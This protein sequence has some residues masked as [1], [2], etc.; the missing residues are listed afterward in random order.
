MSPLSSRLLS[1]RTSNSIYSNAHWRE[2]TRLYI[3]W[4][5]LSSPCHRDPSKSVASLYFPPS[6]PRRLRTPDSPLFCF[7]ADDDYVIDATSVSLAPT[8]S[9]VTSEFT[10][11]IE[12]RRKQV[13]NNRPLLSWPARMLPPTR[14]TLR[15]RY[16]RRE[17]LEGG[18]KSRVEQILPTKKMLVPPF[19]PSSIIASPLHWR[20]G[21]D[22]SHFF[23]QELAMSPELAPQH[24]HSGQ[25]G[26]PMGYVS[27]SPVVQ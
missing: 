7:G 10:L 24:L 12:E 17:N 13:N 25:Y 23:P 9:L 5:R 27:H 1:P 11:P 8:N 15:H 16:N 14:L 20:I 6:S 26:Q 22:S 3:H 4:V 2:A 21:T 19:I 18:V